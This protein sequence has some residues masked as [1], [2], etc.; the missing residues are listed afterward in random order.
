M[1]KRG[2][3]LENFIVNS[4][5][6]FPPIKVLKLSI[7]FSFKFPKEKLEAKMYKQNFNKYLLD[8]Y[9]LINNL[10]EM[11]WDGRESIKYENLQ[12]IKQNFCIFFQLNKSDPFCFQFESFL[13][14]QK[15]SHFF[16]SHKIIH[17][18]VFKSYL[19]IF[20]VMGIFNNKSLDRAFFV[21]NKNFFKV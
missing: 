1:L 8:E 3:F 16:V 21:F 19:L 17:K 10:E 5:I 14:A 12:T 2:K 15:G 6:E 9:G 18:T 13:K 4:F 20:V 11:L 7:D